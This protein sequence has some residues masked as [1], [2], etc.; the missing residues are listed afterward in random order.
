KGGP[1]PWWPILALLPHPL[2]H[3]IALHIAQ[4]QG[5]DVCIR[6]CCPGGGYGITHSLPFGEK[7]RL[8]EQIGLNPSSLAV[9]HLRGADEVL[10]E[11]TLADEVLS[12]QVVCTLKAH[13]EL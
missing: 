11:K 5:D 3:C 12:D 7:G 2:H 10:E 8:Q 13:G 1:E 9:H 6:A 4:V